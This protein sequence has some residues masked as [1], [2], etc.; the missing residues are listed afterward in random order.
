MTGLPALLAF[1]VIVLG[2]LLV[3]VFIFQEKSDGSIK[4]YCIS[5]G[6]TLS[7]LLS[8][9]ALFAVIVLIYG[10][11]FLLFTIGIPEQLLKISVVLLLASA[12]YTLLGIIVEVFFRGISDWLFVGG[13]KN[14]FIRR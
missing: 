14:I 8:K 1:E 6:G 2:F 13:E 4:A 11:F 5:P 3:A 9:T 12:L 7:Y 10:L